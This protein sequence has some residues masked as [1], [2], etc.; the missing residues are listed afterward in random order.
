MFR[1]PGR[2]KGAHEERGPISEFASEDA[3]KKEETREQ[4]PL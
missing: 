3:T 4:G 1:Y 2:E